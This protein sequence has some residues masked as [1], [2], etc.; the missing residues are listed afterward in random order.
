MKSKRRSC[1][2]TAALIITALAAASASAGEAYY[3]W[4]DQEGNPVNSDRPPPAG[5][6]YE[7]VTIDSNVTVSSDPPENTALPQ[8]KP[9]QTGQAEQVEKSVARMEVVKSPEA[10]EAARQNLE[11]LNTHARIRIPDGQGSYRF[12]DEEEKAAER[13]KAQ[14]TIDHNCE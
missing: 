8:A 14:A 11:T 10:C 5:V 7:I 6:S 4:L 3:R 1:G 2:L 9:A 12:I 13:E